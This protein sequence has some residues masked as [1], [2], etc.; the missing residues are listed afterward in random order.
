MT[1]TLPVLASKC[2]D[3]ESYILSNRELLGN[4]TE[5]FFRSDEGFSEFIKITYKLQ[6]IDTAYDMNDTE[7]ENLSYQRMYVWSESAFYLLGP[8]PLLW[9]TLLAINIPETSVAIQL[10]MSL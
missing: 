4:L 5:A 7:Y 8:K 6:I 3:L 1:I 10:P 2:I 9:L